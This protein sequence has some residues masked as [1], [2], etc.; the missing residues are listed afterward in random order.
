MRGL[1]SPSDDE[2]LFDGYDLSFEVFKDSRTGGKE[3]LEYLEAIN[4]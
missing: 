4:I 1:A 3:N 2:E